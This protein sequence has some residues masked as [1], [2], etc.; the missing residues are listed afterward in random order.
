MTSDVNRYVI[1]E[2]QRRIPEAE[3]AV[4]DAREIRFEGPFDVVAPFDVLEHLADLEKVGKD[5]VQRLAPGGALVFVVPVY[6]GPAGPAIRRLDKD[7]AKSPATRRLNACRSFCFSDTRHYQ[8][9]STPKPNHR[10]AS[11][12]YK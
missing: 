8:Q 12:E 7:T 10:L 5:L 11:R 9:T 4:A 3:L 1:E 6:D 2:A